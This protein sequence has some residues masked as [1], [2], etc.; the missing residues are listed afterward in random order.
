MHGC[1]D[2]LLQLLNE[3]EYESTKD[4][5]IL[6]GDIV[7]RG[8]QPVETVR[9]VRGLGLEV[10]LGNHEEKHVRWARHEFRKREDPTYKNPMQPFQPERLAQ[11]NALTDD[12]RHWL[13]K[14]PPFIRFGHDGM[15]WLVTHGGVP[16]DMPVEKQD[17]KLLVRCRYVNTVT[18]AYAG[19]DDLKKPE[20]A[21]YWAERYRG[22]ESVVYGHIVHDDFEIRVDNP[23][24]GVMCVGIDTGCCFGG[25]LTAALFVP[26]RL[27]PV[28][29][30]V[31]ALQTY[32]PRR[33]VNAGD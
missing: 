7:D 33:Q 25:T 12:E 15:T 8:P 14:L 10:V 3:V 4:R 9:Y 27:T 17:P 22:P 18:G 16:A 32:A 20:D 21:V 28:F 26:G 13:A 11:H 19:R 24:P 23:V 2:E 30:S 6:A 31:P 29:V 5:L 1:L